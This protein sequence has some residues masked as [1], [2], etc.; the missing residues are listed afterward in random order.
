[1]KLDLSYLID[2]TGGDREMMLEMIDL[3]LEDIPIQVKKI[4]SLSGAEGIKELGKEAHKLKP[5]LQYVG[6]IEMFE[7]VKEIESICKSGVYSNKIEQLIDVMEKNAVTSI[8]SLLEIRED[9]A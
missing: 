4:K 9:Y 8:P 2:I 6:F 3:F 7:A 1:M 5:T